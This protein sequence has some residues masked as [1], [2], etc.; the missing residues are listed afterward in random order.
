MTLKDEGLYYSWAGLPQLGDQ[1]YSPSLK[2]AVSFRLFKIAFWPYK[3]V[4]RPMVT[5]PKA[6]AN[7]V[8]SSSWV[9]T[10]HMTMMLDHWIVR[11]LFLLLL[12]RSSCGGSRCSPPWAQIDN[13]V[14]SCVY[15]IVSFNQKRLTIL[16]HGI[17]IVLDFHLEITRN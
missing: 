2:N 10:Y 1:L 9:T 17:W 14:V 6:D 13:T 4:W 11:Y 15:L 3:A 16:K 12:E 7:Y 8:K 5:K